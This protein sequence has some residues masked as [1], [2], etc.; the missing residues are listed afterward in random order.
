[1]SYHITATAGDTGLERSGTIVDEPRGGVEQTQ[2]ACAIMLQQKVVIWQHKSSS[3]GFHIME[4]VDISRRV[5][6]ISWMD[7]IIKEEVLRRMGR[8]RQRNSA[9]IQEVEITISRIPYKT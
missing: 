2:R 7:K 4:Y 9:T 1:M 6:K 3:I 5:L 8:N